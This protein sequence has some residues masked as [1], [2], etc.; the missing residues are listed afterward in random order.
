MTSDRGTSIGATSFGG[1]AFFDQRGLAPAKAVDREVALPRPPGVGKAHLA[2]SLAITAAQDGAVLFFQL[3]NAR[4]ERASTV[5]TSNKG[6]EE[7]GSVLGDE[8]MAAAL[9]DR[10][11]HHC[12]TPVP[13]PF[14]EVCSFRLPLTPL[15]I[16]L[17]KGVTP[18]PAP[19]S[20]VCSFRLT[21]TPLMIIQ[22]KGV[23]PVPA[24]FSEVCSF[25]LPLTPLMIMLLHTAGFPSGQPGPELPRRR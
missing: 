8:V 9:I 14:S 25:W 4:H 11:L 2:I 5:L 21:L 12:V 19:F 7:W 23:T 10:L 1:S 18:V 20:E 3:I 22:P 13:A 6:F 16:M 17:P 15:M 24:P